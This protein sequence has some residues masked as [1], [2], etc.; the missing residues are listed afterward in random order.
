MPSSS[1][2]A[3]QESKRMQVVC[4]DHPRIHLVFA[5]EQLKASEERLDVI[6]VKAEHRQDELCGFV[7]RIIRLGQF[8]RVQRFGLDHVQLAVDSLLTL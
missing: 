5:V 1:T 2:E 6:A 7:E 8:V 3:C 4:R